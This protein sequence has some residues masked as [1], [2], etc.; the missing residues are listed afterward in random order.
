MH[1]AYKMYLL[2]DRHFPPLH[3]ISVPLLS[4]LIKSATCQTSKVFILS[5][6]G[7]Q[8]N[9][10]IP[11]EAISAHIM[12]T[13][14]QVISQCRL[15]FGL[16]LIIHC[17]KKGSVPGLIHLCH[18]FPVS[19]VAS[20]CSSLQKLPLYARSPGVCVWYMV[21]VYKAHTSW[22]FD[23]SLRN[24]NVYHLSVVCGSEHIF[25]SCIEEFWNRNT[26]AVCFTYCSCC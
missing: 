5:C 18:S 16:C 4:V 11:Q 2:I 25:H 7:D 1:L 6:S 19:F 24:L 10:S 15:L 17:L 23:K 3:F 13:S 21:H 26:C 14:Q 8:L 9:F 20:V 22:S 12:Y